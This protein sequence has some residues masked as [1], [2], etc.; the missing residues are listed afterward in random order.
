MGS[1]VWSTCSSRA[2][3]PGTARRLP[4]VDGTDAATLGAHA[5]LRLLVHLDLGDQVAGR[6]VPPGEV[7]AG[8]LADQA[9]SAVAPDEVLRPQRRAAGQLDVDAGVVLREAHHLALAEDRHP[10]LLDPAGQDALE[11]ALPEREQV[12]VAGREVA[13][14]EEGPG[15]AHERMRLPRREEPFRDATLVEHLDGARV[16]TPAREPSRS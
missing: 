7:D 4:P 1:P 13:D 15:V 16:Q 9:A 2:A 12:V 10:E 6:R 11:V 8:R 5:D 3:R 14:V